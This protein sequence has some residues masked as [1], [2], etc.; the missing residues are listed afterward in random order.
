MRTTPLLPALLVS[1]ATASAC[2]NPFAY[3]YIAETL[4]QG[5][6]EFEQYFTSRHGRD[7]GTGY[8]A[9][10]RG[11]DVLTELEYGLTDKDQLSFRL[12]HSYV[13]SSARSAFRFDG[14]TIEYQ[15]QLA[16]PDKEAWG[17]VFYLEATYS[18]LARSDASLRSA[19]A[20]EAKYILQHNFGENSPWMYVANV[21]V[22]LGRKPS[23]G[24]T[25][26]EYRISQGIGYQLTPTWAI[27]LES[28]AEAEWVNANVFEAAG[29]FVG[30]SVNYRKDKLSC[31]FTLLR[32][33]VGSRADRGNLNVSEF[34]PTEAR[35]KFSY[36]F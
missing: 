3:S 17:Q 18:G 7:I 11:L 22:E 19:Y 15:R 1:F 21:S 14:V 5:R 24:E 30:P 29:L 27:G 2:D 20:L 16:N 12:N 10:Y 36:E 6:Y 33:V 8:E 23:E 28:V 13:H 25:S 34:S 26:Y 35:L 31:T 32:Q 9:A 4:K